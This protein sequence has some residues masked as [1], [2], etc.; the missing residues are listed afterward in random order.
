MTKWICNG[1]PGWCEANVSGHL[2][3]VGCLLFPKIEAN[4]KRDCTT[5]EKKDDLKI[6]DKNIL[7]VLQAMNRRIAHSEEKVQDLIAAGQGQMTR[8]QELEQMLQ[9]HIHYIAGTTGKPARREK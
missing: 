6:T 2:S 8:I 1:C 4:W 3:P 9:N 7:A 5:E